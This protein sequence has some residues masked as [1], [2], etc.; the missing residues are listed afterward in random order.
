MVNISEN[1]YDFKDNLLASKRYWLIYLIFIALTWFST[2]YNYDVLHPKLQVVA[3]VFIALLG[4]FCIVYYFMHSSDDEL[5]KV[6]FVIILSFGLICC[7]AVPI[8]HHVDELEHFTRAEITSDGV[9]FP[10]W[11]GDERGIDRLYNASSGVSSN[12]I[13]KDVGFA[14][15]GSLK[16]FETNRTMTVYD[17]PHDTD[18]INSTFYLRGSAFEQN[19]F[20]GYLPQAIGMFIAKILDLNV[21]WLLWLGRIFNIIFYAGIVSLAVKK[22]PGL[23]MPMIAVA[24]IPVAIYQSASV[25]ID[26][27]IFALGLLAI[28]Y[29]M[30]LYKSDEKS[31][32]YKHVAIYSAICLLLGLCKLP[33][34]AFVFLLLFV[35]KK[36]F[37][38]YNI[39]VI[40]LG[41]L[42]VAAVG[43]LWSRYSTPALMHSWRSSYNLIDSSKQMDFLLSDPSQIGVFLKHTV[44]TGP[45]DMM[46]ELFNYD[47][48]T[49]ESLARYMP[50]I[51]LLEIFLAIVLFAYPSDIKFDLKAKLGALFVFVVVYIG[52]FFVQ[53]LTWA[54]VGDMF[55]DVH[56]RYFIPLFAL[57]PIIVQ[58]SRN[59]FKRE[60]FDK[61]ALVFI[62]GF[63]ATLVLA[64][65]TR[66]Y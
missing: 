36:N 9:I 42:A 10:D 23:K 31:L 6:A 46:S 19:P 43:I 61:Y 34:L 26:A 38:K 28:A 35:P 53:L 24:C 27:M 15:I 66:Y 41:I 20:Y 18:K 7:L 1:L 17:T 8:C 60:M 3:L 11:I 44:T 50:I 32:D 14:S 65:F 45:W 64:V 39:F 48:W 22:A 12:L 25:S 13:N 63:A 37:K 54:S 16:F 59:P 30:Y 33:Y 21:I 51:V 29:F 58:F 55:V 62:V 56:V 57:I 2:V 5:Y 52:T 4:V 47:Y 49:S 40:L